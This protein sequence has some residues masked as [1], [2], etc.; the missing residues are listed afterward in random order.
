VILHS[1]LREARAHGCHRMIGYVLAQNMRMLNVAVRAGMRVRRTP[2][3]PGVCVVSRM[4]FWLPR[5][6]GFGTPQHSL[7]RRDDGGRA[8]RGSQPVRLGQLWQS[9]TRSV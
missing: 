7:M 1:L 8:W 4:L 5:R 6:S 2:T 3:D 9:R